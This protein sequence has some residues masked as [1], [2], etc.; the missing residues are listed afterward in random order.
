[1]A[2]VGVSTKGMLDDGKTRALLPSTLCQP[3]GGRQVSVSYA[4]PAARARSRDG[5]QARALP[6]E[7][8]SRGIDVDADGQGVVS[9]Q[10]LYQTRSGVPIRDRSFDV[11]FLDPG[12]HAL[13]FTF[14]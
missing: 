8:Q 6:G 7:G 11:R 13:A 4:Q 3:D 9:E 1:M 2:A 14:G 12:A 10:R 5:R